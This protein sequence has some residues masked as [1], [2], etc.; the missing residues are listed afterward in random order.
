MPVKERISKLEEE[1]QEV[2]GERDETEATNRAE[3]DSL[4]GEE[5]TLL[6]VNKEIVRLGPQQWGIDS[7][8][9]RLSP[10][11]EGESLGTRLVV[12]CYTL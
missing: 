2:A 10:C 12:K 7:L 6:S 5:Q 4:R 1:R 9:P 8:V 3:V 11:K